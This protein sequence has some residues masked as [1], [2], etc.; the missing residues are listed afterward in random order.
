MSAETQ[1]TILGVYWYFGF[2]D[3]LYSYDYFTFHPG[4]GGHA[5]N[6][7]E[8]SAVVTVTDGD[9]FLNELKRSV[10]LHPYCYLRVIVSRNTF[11]ISTGGY[12]L[13][14]FDFLLI[15]YVESVLKKYSA[16]TAIPQKYDSP[17]V[18]QF[19]GSKLQQHTYPRLAI[20]KITGSEKKKSNA[21]VSAVRLDC[22]MVTEHVQQFAGTMK[23][24]LQNSGI[25][26]AYYYS[27][28]NKGV[29]NML[30]IFTNGRQGIEGPPVTVNLPE[31]EKH[32]REIMSQYAVK[33]DHHK[34][35][36]YP[37]EGEPTILLMR[38]KDYII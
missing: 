27:S 13:F 19:I 16:T 21:E 6:P 25:D 1:K 36:D 20:L 38:D 26:A 14:D 12:Q 5:D 22:H 33:T 15:K 35:V 29:S 2:P 11:G 4:Y 23:T 34:E 31:L 7:A 18:H 9:N 3:G 30:L 17:T 28:A 24:L 32:I 37:V 8:L 10:E